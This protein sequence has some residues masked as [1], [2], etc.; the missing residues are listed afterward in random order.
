MR[1]LR[2]AQVNEEGNIKGS[3][4]IIVNGSSRPF[5]GNRALNLNIR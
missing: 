3:L 1:P 5:N 4:I 2:F